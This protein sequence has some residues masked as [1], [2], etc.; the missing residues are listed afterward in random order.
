MGADN[1]IRNIL[2]C[3]AVVGSIAIIQG[4]VAQETVRPSEV[5]VVREGWTFVPVVA[6]SNGT[7]S[8]HGVLA[9]RDMEQVVGDNIVAVWYQNP[10]AAGE[11]WPA[12]S[13]ESQDQWKAIKW[14][15]E[16]TGVEDRWDYLWPSSTPIE[17]AFSEQPV[18]YSAGLL[19]GDPLSEIASGSDAQEWLQVLTAIG[20]KSASI[21]ID[22]DG[23]CDKTI[24]LSALADSAAYAMAAPDAT[25]EDIESF[26]DTL[27]PLTWNL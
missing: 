22:M 17:E 23:P 5:R 1:R 10:G 20:Y 12:V 3:I 14:V 16:Q 2:A 25:A 26:Y 6:S 13:W 15:K 11:S 24:V 8:V 27:V 18:E 21:S 4:A 19:E 7:I 9:L